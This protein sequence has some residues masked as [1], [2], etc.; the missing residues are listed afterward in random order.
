MAKLLDRMRECRAGRLADPDISGYSNEDLQTFLCEDIPQEEQRKTG[1]KFQLPEEI[2]A[3][4]DSLVGLD[5]VRRMNK[6]Q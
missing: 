5:R 6:H 1:P 2:M 4:L 3:E